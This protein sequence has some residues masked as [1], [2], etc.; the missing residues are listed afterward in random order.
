MPPVWL[1]SRWEPGNIIIIVVVI[2]IIIVTVITTIYCP[3]T[4]F[5]DVLHCCR[6]G[7]RWKRRGVRYGQEK[8]EG[9]ERTRNEIKDVRE[10]EYEKVETRM[11]ENRKLKKENLN[12]NYK[13]T[14]HA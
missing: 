8:D 14:N 13:F 10:L 2:I 4:T 12:P 7:K 1:L 5:C 3:S 11:K 6:W 9:Q